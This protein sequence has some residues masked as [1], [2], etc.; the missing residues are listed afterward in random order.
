ML[1]KEKGFV[2]A[3]Q[4]N[5]KNVIASGWCRIWLV[6]PMKWASNPSSKSDSRHGLKS[7]EIQ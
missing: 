6:E 4:K 2:E 7:L 5:T 3:G 1:I